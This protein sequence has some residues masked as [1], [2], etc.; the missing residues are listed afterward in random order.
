MNGH[1]HEFGGTASSFFVAIASSLACKPN[2]CQ[3][4]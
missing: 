2:N 1:P 4:L 3:A